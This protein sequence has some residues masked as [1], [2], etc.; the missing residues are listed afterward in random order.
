MKLPPKRGGECPAIPSGSSQVLIIGANGAGKTRFTS[1]LLSSVP[2]ERT[3]ALSPLRA[4]F[5]AFRP[6]AEVG[7]VDAAYSRALTKS[8]LGAS[9]VPLASEFERL[10]GLLL[11]EEMTNLLAY[12]MSDAKGPLPETKLDLVI[13]QWRE[14]FPGNDILRTE[15]SLLFAS[16][17]DG[18]SRS[19]TKLSAGEKVVL[20]YFGGVLLAPENAVIYID[21]PEMFLHPSTLRRVWDKVETMRP[22]C[23]FVYTTHDL[24][25]AATRSSATT[26][27]IRGWQA[28]SDSFDYDILPPDSELREDMYLS[29]LG[30]RRPV[31]FIEGDKTHSIDSKLYP[32]IFPDY[33][34]K[35]LGSCDRVIESTRVFNSLEAFHHLDSRG[36]VDRD[37]RSPQ[38][39]EYLR[40]KKI[41]VPEVAEIEN[42]LLL[43]DVVKAVAAVHRRDEVR[44]FEKTKNAVIGMFR[45]E[46]RQQALQHTRHNVKHIMEHRIDGRFTSITKLEEHMNGLVDEINPRAIYEQFCRDFSDYIK[47][48][49][50]EAILRVYNQKSMVG[51]SNVSSLTGCGDKRSYLTAVLNILKTN[52]HAANRIRQAIRSRIR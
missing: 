49:D 14:I 38:E 51:Q 41:M 25:F 18:S 52:S 48:G 47:R 19:Q 33:T 28:D 27:W 2:P 1:R 4:L 12:K 6:D 42:L 31:L 16:S 46:M 30:A 39:V 24:D 22:D 9:T 32:L 5:G 29:I 50:Y 10:L 11:Q 21:S 36:I 40:R 7:S 3:F 44:A 8:P 45:A 26:I 34:V 20:Y 35:A 37:R 17:A 43:E 13:A 23:T 15:G